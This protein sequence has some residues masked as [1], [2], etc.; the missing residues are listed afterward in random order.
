M[1]QNTLV[2]CAIVGFIAW[3]YFNKFQES[4]REYYKLYKRFVEVSNE[5][6]RIKA[7]VKDL[8]TYKNDVSKTFKILDN[9][10]L[11]INDHIKKQPTVQ[12]QIQRFSGQPSNPVYNTQP[13]NR[14]SML[15]PELLSTLFSNM[16]QD[17][18]DMNQDGMDMNQDGMGM[19]QDGMEINQDGNA[20]LQL[21]H[22][23]QNDASGE[24]NPQSDQ[25]HSHGPQQQNAEQSDVLATLSYEINMN[26]I[27][28]GN[29][30][31]RFLINE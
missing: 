20:Q 10:L 26:P 11:M 29:N 7:R 5:N 8:Q 6:Q 30:Y 3:Y 25:E 31:N 13:A 19:N 17:G 4:E 16:N 12:P 24:S 14:I 22:V 23:Q 2:I 1:F 15:T 21:E 27:V 28:P 9:E 18:M